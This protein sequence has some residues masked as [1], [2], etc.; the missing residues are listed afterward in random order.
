MLL[1]LIRFFEKKSSSVF[2]HRV[3]S[4]LLPQA[5]IMLSKPEIQT[6]KVDGIHNDTIKIIKR[7]GNKSDHGL[8]SLGLCNQEQQLHEIRIE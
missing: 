1:I 7:L 6:S 8:D 2:I 4:A 3:A 5:V